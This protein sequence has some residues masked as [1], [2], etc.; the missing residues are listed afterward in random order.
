MVCMKYEMKQESDGIRSDM[1][2]FRQEGI[3][4]LALFTV[5]G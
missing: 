1:L 2:G 3:A 5:P 4:C